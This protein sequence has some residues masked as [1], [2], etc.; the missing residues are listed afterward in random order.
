MYQPVCIRVC[1]CSICT[2]VCHLCTLLCTYVYCRYRRSSSFCAKSIVGK[3]Y[4]WPWLCIRIDSTDVVGFL[5]LNWIWRSKQVSKVWLCLAPIQGIQY[6]TVQYSIVSRQTLFFKVQLAQ[7]PRSALRCNCPRQASKQASKQAS[8]LSLFLI[9]AGRKEGRQ[10]GTHF[11]TSLKQ[12]LLQNVLTSALLAVTGLISRQLSH[13]AKSRPTGCRDILFNNYR[14]GN[15]VIAIV[16]PNT[17]GHK[18]TVLR[19][20]NTFSFC[21]FRSFINNHYPYESVPYVSHY[22]KRCVN[23]LMND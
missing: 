19:H 8:V 2:Y 1:M 3:A 22:V 17:V 14:D 9:E 10:A 4:I 6:S 16:S 21:K 5:S 11:H 18:E 13:L 12:C 7:Q 15:L 23:E 20:T